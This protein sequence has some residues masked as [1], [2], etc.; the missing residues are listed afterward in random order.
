MQP[1]HIIGGGLAGCEGG[2]ADARRSV[3]VALHEEMRRLG[4]LIMTASDRAD[5]RV[6]RQM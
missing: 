1:V 5:C 6:V 3:P 4:S 2:V